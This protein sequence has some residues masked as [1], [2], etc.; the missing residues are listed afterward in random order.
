[1]TELAIDPRAAAA[2]DDRAK[3]LIVAVRQVPRRR[4]SGPS[5]QPDIPIAATLSETDIVGEIDAGTTDA[6]DAE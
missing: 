1:M 5:W 2:I 4:P 3:R 6:Q